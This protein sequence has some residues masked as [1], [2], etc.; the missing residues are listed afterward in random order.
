MVLKIAFIF[1]WS[2]G[3]GAHDRAKLHF[4]QSKVAA[5]LYLSIKE[6]T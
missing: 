2:I 6:V 5:A 3:Q 4:E 1:L